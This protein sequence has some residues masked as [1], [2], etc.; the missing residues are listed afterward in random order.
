[1]LRA[2]FSSRSM[3]SPQEV[4]TWVRTLK[5]LG[6]RAPQPLQSWLVY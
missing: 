5:L 4:Q 2:A 1:M 3:T 6:T